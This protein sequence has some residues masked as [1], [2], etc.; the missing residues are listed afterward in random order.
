MHLNSFGS[1]HQSIVI[2]DGNVEPMVGGARAIDGQ[3][4]PLI[5]ARPQCG[6]IGI[7]DRIIAFVVT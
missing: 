1:H 3:P 2:V 7:T 5:I 6:V 4:H